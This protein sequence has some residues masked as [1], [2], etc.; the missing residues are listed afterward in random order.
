MSIKPIRF[1][2][3]AMDRLPE[4]GT[5][6][7]EVCRAIRE[8]SRQPAKHNRIMC[9]LNLQF[10]DSWQGKNYEIKQVAPVIAETASE[11]VVVTVYT[12]YF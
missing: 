9:Q 8:G 6:E 12:F 11:I 10:R 5:N 2:R 7:E 3:H 4:R 1:S